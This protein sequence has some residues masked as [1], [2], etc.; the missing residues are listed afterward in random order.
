MPM[1]GSWR[2]DSKHDENQVSP[3]QFDNPSREHIGNIDDSIKF[4]SEKQTCSLKRCNIDET[5][6]IS[7]ETLKIIND[8]KA[9]YFKTMFVN[10]S[11]IID[12]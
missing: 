8:Y 9:Q 2:C 5:L 12:D 11:F 3:K 10:D 1:D 6:M 4:S 7:M